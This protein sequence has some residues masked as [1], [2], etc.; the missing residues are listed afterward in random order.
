MRT[1]G[2]LRG[3]AGAVERRLCGWGGCIARQGAGA[4]MWTHLA[5]AEQQARD[6]LVVRA[7]EDDVGGRPGRGGAKVTRLELRRARA[8]GAPRPRLRLPCVR[9][10]VQRSTP[11]QR[12]TA[13][14]NPTGTLPPTGSP[15]ECRPCATHSPIVAQ[16][17]ASARNRGA[18]RG[19]AGGALGCLLAQVV[20]QRLH[21]TRAARVRLAQ[22]AWRR[23]RQAVLPFTWGAKRSPARQMGNVPVV[24][25][26]GVPAH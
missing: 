7:V 1:G 12:E 3:A 10:V 17:S 16:P 2:S 25:A 6:A 22:P 14:P 21:L 4:G 18:Y 11:A 13:N 5:A 9:A 23:A 20:E 15:R 24:I 8:G 19:G 26:C